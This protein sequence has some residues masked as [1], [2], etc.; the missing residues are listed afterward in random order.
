MFRISRLTDYGTIIL[1]YLGDQN[2]RLCSATE[3][4]QATRVAGPTVSKLLQVLARGGIVESV[5]GADG[6]Y[7]LALAPEAISAA[8][9]LD[10]LEGPVAITECST[11]DS[12]CEFEPLC[13]TGSAWQKIN[14]VIQSALNEISL[15]DLANPPKEFPLLEI[16]R[17]L[18]KPAKPEPRADQG[19][20]ERKMDHQ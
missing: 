12:H 14:R 10:V 6:G 17:M 5:R 11:D 1:V 16:A 19:P 13:Q 20:L 2:E 9:I 7:R 8:R 15:A 18:D 4:A 3:V